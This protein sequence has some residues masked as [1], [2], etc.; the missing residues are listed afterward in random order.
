LVIIVVSGVLAIVSRRFMQMVRKQVE[1]Q[2]I[3]ERY[4]LR[5][6]TF[7]CRL[8][9]EVASRTE[10]LEA[11][12]RVLS[13]EVRQRKVNENLLAVSL[14]EKEALVKE[15]NHRVKNNLQVIASIINMQIAGVDDPK[16]EDMLITLK[17]RI[18]SMSRV[19][20]RL[21]GCDDITHINMDDYLRELVLGVGEAFQRPGLALEI[22]SEASGITF[23]V[24][25]ATTIG[26]IV[27]E[28]V[29]NSVKHAFHGLERGRIEVLLRKKEGRFELC[30]SDD[31]IG[32]G[33]EV[34]AKIGEC[35]C[36]GF[37][38]VDA[39]VS[40]LRGELRRESAGGLINV[41]AFD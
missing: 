37:L 2:E 17:N 32:L 3:S 24:D 33:A 5:L 22:T 9:D 18:F 19:Q 28:L 38:L 7:N 14:A 21:Y 15:V 20:D 13:T 27:S 31:G 10:D 8:E 11:L 6:S 34:E 26:L 16:I 25:R 4:A 1:L 39:L 30:I 29:S 41:V 40:Q 36:I 12:N 35:G 23:T